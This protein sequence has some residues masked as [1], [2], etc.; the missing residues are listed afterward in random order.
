M[1]LTK[2]G[3][4]TQSI[5]LNDVESHKLHLS[6]DVAVGETIKKGAPVKLNATGQV[7]NMIGDGTDTHQRIGYSIQNG[8]A[9]DRLTVGVRG[10]AVVWARAK[11]ALTPGPVFMAGYDVNEPDFTMYD[12]TAVSASTMNGFSLDVAAALHDPIRVLVF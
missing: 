10:Y 4:K 7:V 8:I 1:A 6:F 9:G 11:T 12:D 2:F 3:D 5:F